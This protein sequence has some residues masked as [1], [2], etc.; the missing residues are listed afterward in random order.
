MNF[1][2]LDRLNDRNNRC[3]LVSAVCSV[4][5]KAVIG[6]VGRGAREACWPASRRAGA[7]ASGAAAST[8]RDNGASRPHRCSFTTA[9]GC[10]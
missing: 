2:D 10:P 8:R 7:A 6:G 9:P 4:A 3:G 5:E 1:G